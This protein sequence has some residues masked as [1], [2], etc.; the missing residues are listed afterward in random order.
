MFP[1]EPQMVCLQYPIVQ[2]CFF[3]AVK[4]FILLTSYRPALSEAK[5]RVQCRR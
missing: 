1:N 5:A 3:D 2:V 4:G